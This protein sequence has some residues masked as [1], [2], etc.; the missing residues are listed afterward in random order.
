MRAASSRSPRRATATPQIPAALIA[1]TAATDRT[2]SQAIPRQRAEPAPVLLL[3]VFN[4][5]PAALDNSPAHRFPSADRVEQASG[6]GGT[7]P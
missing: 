2:V 3:A 5:S 6:H 1:T 4:G 7:L